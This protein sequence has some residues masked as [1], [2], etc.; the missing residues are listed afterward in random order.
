MLTRCLAFVRGILHRRAIDA[1]IDEELQFHLEQEVQ[2]HVDRGVSPE[3]ARRLANLGLGGVA[4]TRDAVR[5][6]RTTWVEAT[7]R[8]AR[9]GMRA[10]WTMPAFTVPALIVLAL[11]IGGTTA[12]FSVLDGVLLRPLPY[13]DADELV[14]VWSR[15]DERRIPFLSVSPA[16]FEDWR[17]R[18]PFSLQLGAYDRPR[19]LPLRD[20]AEP[21]TVMSVTQG[22]FGARRSA[23]DRTRFRDEAYRLCRCDQPRV[24]AALVWR[25]A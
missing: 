6:I 23:R 4:Q 25:R 5:D 19:V 15:N 24:L 20:S 1:E 10:L 7:W 21:V 14:R 16:D 18:A 12:V 22:L 9:Q 13:P 3:E 2:A 8:E 11:G 17:A